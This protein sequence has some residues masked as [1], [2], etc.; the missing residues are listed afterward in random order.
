MTT[1]N[2]VITLSSSHCER[3]NGDFLSNVRF[4]FPH[5]LS[6]HNHIH[7]NTVSIQSAEIPHSFYNVDQNH[8]VVEYQVNSADYT[9]TIPEGQ[10]NVNTLIATFQTLFASD[11]H[12]EECTMTFDKTTGKLALILS[13]C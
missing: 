12:G 13:P 5:V 10:Y 11:A 3:L 6:H 7:Y 1:L 4:N 9:M 8:N 2:K